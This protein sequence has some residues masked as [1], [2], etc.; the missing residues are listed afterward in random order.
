MMLLHLTDKLLTSRRPMQTLGAP[1]GKHFNACH[2]ILVTSPP[3][4]QSLLRY[5]NRQTAKNNHSPKFDHLK[6]TVKDNTNAG[7]EGF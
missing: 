3:G 2:K 6:D 7:D 5:K 4:Y 1:L